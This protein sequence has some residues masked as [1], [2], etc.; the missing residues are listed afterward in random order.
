M[1]CQ[2][3][4]GSRGPV[5]RVRDGEDQGLDIA[6]E[7]RA[8]THRTRLLGREDRRVGQAYRTELSGCLAEHDDD[9]V[10]RGIVCLLD[11][12]VS[13]DDHRLVDDGDRGIGAFAALHRRSRLG[14]CLAHEELVVHGA[15]LA[16]GLRPPVASIVRHPA[17]TDPPPAG[18]VA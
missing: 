9:G 2:L 7:Q 8:D 16:D 15:M 5:M 4:D 18:A 11:T 17:A 1:L 6:L 14:Q 13:P 10:G 12:V 3:D